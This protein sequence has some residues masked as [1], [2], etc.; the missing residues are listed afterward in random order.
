M[1]NSLNIKANLSVVGYVKIN[2]Y[3][4]AY[5]IAKLYEKLGEFERQKRIKHLGVISDVFESS[6]HS[7]YEYLLL[8]CFLT[9]IAE[10]TYKGDANTLGSITIDSKSYSGNA[11]IKSWFLLSNF[12]HT[13]RTIGDE[14][15][16]LQFTKE[17]KGFRNKLLSDIIDEELK[18][19][20]TGVIDNYDYSS[21]H[22][23]LSIWRLY[24]NCRSKP[25]LARI[26]KIYKLYLLDN[27]SVRVDL[28]KLN[29][30]KYLAVFIREVAV[31]SIDGHYTHLPV[32]INPLSVI[33][34]TDLFDN[35]FNQN[36]ILSF[37]SPISSLLIENI[38]QNQNVQEKQRE[39]EV[40]SISYLK[41]GSA[42]YQS[43]GR[44]LEKAFQSGLLEERSITLKH[45]FRFK[46]PRTVTDR[47]LFDEFRTIQTVK[48]NSSKVE[49]S[50]DYNAIKDELVYDFYF[51]NGFENKYLPTFLH[52]ILSILEE[53]IM[54]SAYSLITPLQELED[55]TRELFRKYNISQDEI[56][57]IFEKSNEVYYKDLVVELKRINMPCFR[58]LVWS[59]IKWCLKD[60][61]TFEIAEH[62]PK[63]EVVAFKLNNINLNT[64]GYNIDLAKKNS[65]DKDKNHELE[66]LSHATKRNF[67]GFVLA[68]LCRINIYDSLMPPEQRPV[69]DID[70]LLIKVSEN[71]L[72][73]E[74]NE[75]KNT[76]KS[77][78]KKARKDL[79]EKFMKVL[80]SNAK[81]TK[82]MDVKNYGAK[83]RLRIKA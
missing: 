31:I 44:L 8:Q 81:G 55:N 47:N 32:N 24:K 46:V 18:K 15:S 22:H 52:N 80:N 35:R 51:Q 16:L 73:I 82:I 45:F 68:C 57:P 20:C 66:H 27:C 63:Y 36:S 4:F 56:N 3:D 14:K 33:M 40:N 72:I 30:L 34:S 65:G 5:E 60:N 42:N 38:Y 70:S 26:L 23:V 43:Y 1:S 29:L 49:A 48:R 6:S 10:K 17:R 79:R 77:A 13:Y 53:Q 69:T 21:F 58:G 9:D 2:F 7:R 64:I 67:D 59:L 37:L 61:Y 25:E 11:I 12:G 50:L 54:S 75:S 76:K 28:N 78:F 71:E 39:Y 19:Y 74:F 62:K 83:A 41:S